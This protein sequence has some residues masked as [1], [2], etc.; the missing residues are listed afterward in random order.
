MGFGDH[1][2][3]LPDGENFA[4]S[5]EKVNK[6]AK[7][8]RAEPFHLGIPSSN[9]E[10]WVRW[11]N[12]SLGQHWLEEA[13]VQTS[14][15]IN[16]ITNDL[17]AQSYQKDSRAV[18]TEINQ[19]VRDPLVA[20]TMSE[21]TLNDDGSVTI[22]DGDKAVKVIVS[23]DDGAFDFGHGLIEESATPTRLSWKLREPVQQARVKISVRPV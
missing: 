8:L 20:M 16:R 19:E 22:F 9:R 4:P 15:D 13:Q 23:S 10:A 12:H 5:A 3:N 18:Y 17:M 11:K 2:L 7:L 21:W 1:N 14:K 6:M